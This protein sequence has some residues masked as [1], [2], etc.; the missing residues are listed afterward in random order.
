MLL[1]CVLYLLSKV[2][3][4]VFLRELVDPLAVLAFV[5]VFGLL[6]RLQYLNDFRLA[7][8]TLVS[9][10]EHESRALLSV[11]RALVLPEGLAV[12]LRDRVDAL[13]HAV[14]RSYLPHGIVSTRQLSLRVNVRSANGIAVSILHARDLLQYLRIEVDLDVLWLLRVLTLL[15]V[16]AFLAPGVGGLVVLYLDYLRLQLLVHVVLLFS[17]G[18]AVPDQ[19]VVS[20]DA[21][22]VHFLEVDDASRYYNF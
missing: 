3:S 22:R 5:L 18:F 4:G 15:T 2:I 19:I 9:W 13:R 14:L 10:L 16:L 17:S 11:E 12:G 20:L 8:Q 21:E 1:G 7:H 6:E